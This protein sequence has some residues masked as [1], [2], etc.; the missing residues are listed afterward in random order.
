[1]IGTTIDGRYL[2]ESV[3]GE[4]GMGMVYGGRHAI[5]DKRV[6]IKVLRKEA[7]TDEHAA[8]RFLAEAKAASKIGQQNIVDITDFG[9]LPDGHAYFVMEFLDGPTLGRVL[10]KGGPMAPDR[11]VGIA[12]Q[13]ARGLGAAHNK[14]IVHRDLK[15]D[16]IFV[17]DREGAPDFVKIVDFGIARDAST[18]KRL[19]VAGM[20]MGTPEYMAPEQASGQEIDHRAD[21]YALGCILYEAL[22]GSTPFRGD[23]PMQT[24]TRH[25]FDTVVPPSKARPDLTIPAS[26]EAVVLKTLAKSREER[27]ANLEELMK[28]LQEIAPSLRG[29]MVP[30]QA[31]AGVGARAPTVTT[32]DLEHARPAT[33]SRK[34]P[35]AFAA[36]LAFAGIVAV[37]LLVTRKP[38]GP[39]VP[40]ASGSPVAPAKPAP[41]AVPSAPVTA[42]IRVGSV[43]ITLDSVP[44]GAE[45]FLG[46]ELIGTTPTKTLQP[47]SEAVPLEFQFRKPGFRDTPKAVLATTDAYVQVLLVREA[48]V[49]KRPA[50]P[51]PTPTVQVAAKPRGPAQGTHPGTER[52]KRPQSDLRNPFDEK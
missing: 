52:P 17:L 38:S 23:N 26:I 12:L 31:A 8:Q 9:V 44:P 11:A 47:R 4:G 32:P 18:K 40:V 45:V 22:T 42:P 27:Y 34:G 20:V 43:T 10:Q 46:D 50:H 28:A 6:A 39:A 14:G 5:I 19:T 25:V 33:G 48:G 49:A 35:L 24:L 37:G 2:V 15:P 30:T 13:V 3:L 36:A 29:I 21:Q 1:M 51:L 7:A 41:P 16:N